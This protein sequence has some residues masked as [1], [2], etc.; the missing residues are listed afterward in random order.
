MSLELLKEAFKV[1]NLVGEDTIENI[2]ENDIIVPDIK[3][4]IAKVLLLDGD[5]FVTGCDTGTDRAVVSGCIVA[6]ILYISDDETR[7][8]KSIT[9]NIPFSYTMDIQGIRSGMKS[10]AK[11][12]IEHMD[13]TLLNGRKINIKAILSLNCRVTDE[14]EKDISSGISGVEDIQVLKDSI[15]INTFLGSN[16]VNYVM[17]E[18]MEL[19]ATKPPIAEILRNDVRISGKDFKI[20][21]GR[22]VVKGD[23]NIS[24]LYIADDEARSMQYME[25]E[26]T[27]TQFVELEDITEDTSIDVDYDL[28]DYKIESFE[29]GDGE[30]RNLRA[31]IALNIYVDGLYQRNFDVLSDAY[32]PKAK[33]SLEKQQ[34]TIDRTVADTRGQIIVKDSFSLED[35]SPEVL[36][37]FNVLCKCNVSETRIDDDKLTIEGSV[38]NNIIYLSNNEEE[39]VFCHNKELPFTH[40]MDIKGIKS[41]MRS[42]INV[43]VEHCNY[44]M[45]STNQLEIRVAL[46]VNARVET[47]SVVPIINKAIE[48]TM[49]EKKLLS[50]PS[51]V[52]YIVQPGDS[53]W[54][55][56]KKYSTTVDNLLRINNLNEKDILMPGQQILIL[57]R[58]V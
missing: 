5:I 33:I 48:G 15:D 39:P 19:P 25:N 21:D 41:D 24:T 27:F 23:V 57:K 12:I 16:K 40:V 52:L 35:L 6:K 9:S 28:V 20:A 3:P 14:L 43:E 17:K 36:E 29:D 7:S 11:G 46:G 49:D 38:V 2:V 34:F 47:K 54:K 58:A 8:V 45:V 55:I 42:D 13:Y 32:S 53:L 37:I 51:V 1:N 50:L 44:S 10:R 18:D 22:V 31:E 56:A 30:Q 4:D 26:L